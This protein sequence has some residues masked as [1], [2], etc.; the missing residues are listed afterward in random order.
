LTV[1]AGWGDSAFSAGTRWPLDGESLAATVYSTG[2]PARIDDYSE[3]P[4]ALA[5]A[6]RADGFV[7]FAGAPIVVRGK[8]WGLISAASRDGR[9]QSDTEGRLARFTELVATAITNAESQTEVT[10]LA[11][12]QSA[13]RRVATLVAQGVPAAEVFAAVS[14]E[15]GRLVG[16]DSATVMKF[17]EDGPGILFVGVASKMSDTYP[18]GARWEFVDGMASAEVYRTGRSARGGGR[19]WGTVDG[20][21]GETHHRLGIVSTVATPIVVEGHLWGCIAV[22]SQEPLPLDTDQRLASFTELVATAIANAE[23][24]EALERLVDEQAALRRVATLVARGV[25]ADEIFAA[26]S[27]EVGRLVGTDSATVIRYDDDGEGITFVGVASKMSGTFPLGG[28]WKFQEGMASLDVYRTGRSAR[29]GAH[30]TTVDGPVG[31]THRRMGIISA[32]ASPIVVEGRL[33]G[34]MAVHGHE[35]LPLDTDERLE[36]F[37]EL[38]ATA[39]ANAESGAGITRLAEEQAALRRVATLV[40]RGAPPAELFAAVSEEV[41]HL[42]AFDVANLSRYE[43]DRTIT[44]LAAWSRTGDPFPTPGSRWPIGGKNVTTLV[45]ETGRSARVDDYANASGVVAVPFRDAGVRSAVGTPIIVEGRLWGVM[46]AGSN[47]DQPLPADTEARL[48]SFTELVATA[49]ANTESRAGLG[50]LAEQQAALRRVATLVAEGVPPAKLLSAVCEE[51]SQLLDAQTSSIMRLEADGTVTV[52]ANGGTGEPVFEVGTRTRPGPGRVISAVLDTGRPARREA[53]DD[54]SEEASDD[55]S[56]RARS[57]RLAALGIRS[58][59]AV[60]IVVEG[61]LWGVIGTA[62]VREHFAND[63]EQRLE[64]F[65]ELAATAIANADSRAALT[66]SRARIVAA[67]DETRRRIERDLHD[68]IQQRLVS[69]A[70][71]VRAAEMTPQLPTGAQAELSLLFDGLRAAIDEVRETSRGIHPAVLSESGL[72]PAL[73]ALTA[74]VPVPVKLELD[75]DDRLP[76]RVEAAAYYVASEA[77]ANALKHAK[78]SVVELRAECRDGSLTLVLR[79]DGIGGADPSRGSGLIGLRDRV[80]ALGGTISVASPPGEGTVLD[81]RL[82]IE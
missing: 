17:D 36:K 4:G 21:V 66:A 58:T 54:T 72:K 5:A 10:R 35:P 43:P 41:G 47:L 32:V 82:P 18:L 80:E 63:T 61:A 1:V 74:R 77:L 39:I 53:S 76:E 25:R 69:L 2:R 40:A 44:S 42:L 27:D 34:A 71:R 68:G 60:P 79:D 55:T 48:A 37:T 20:P 13:L 11:E 56:D 24:R 38:V 3:L 50:R 15:V 49:I 7:S 30:L 19:D 33:W 16:T 6:V 12:E 23:A 9:L 8:V 62:T 26:V 70:L 51:V 45:F 14:D 29:S 75:L 78:A 46:S 59:V 28:S 52:W 57:L 31:D 65:T 64:E 73:K 22:Q 81:V 67:S